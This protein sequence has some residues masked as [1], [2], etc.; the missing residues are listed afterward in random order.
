MLTS[1]PSEALSNDGGELKIAISHLLARALLESP[2]VE[3]REKVRNI[4]S[5]LSAKHSDK[6][7]LLLLKL[8]LFAVE[9]N[10][11]HE[12]YRD[13]LLRIVRSAH[14]TESTLKTIMHYVHNLRSL[15]AHLAHDVL[16]AL[17]LERLSSAEQPEWVEKVLITLIWNSTTS[18]NP[19]DHI[20]S[21]QRLFLGLKNQ[22]NVSIGFSA[23]HAAHVVGIA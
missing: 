11:P 23:A 21:L 6:M 15:S 17:L 12:D 4:V 14:V 22:N 20:R 7:F 13:V 3:A 1:Q 18:S 9:P 8:D 2:D 10:I 19:V 5:D 16:K